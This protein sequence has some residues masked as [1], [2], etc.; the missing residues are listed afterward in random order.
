MLL[1]LFSLLY[2]Y[3][4]TGG[5]T[6]D[7]SLVKSLIY[8]LSSKYTNSAPVVFDLQLVTVLGHL[9]TLNVVLESLINSPVLESLFSN[10]TLVGKFSIKLVTD[11]D[12]TIPPFVSVGKLSLK[13]YSTK[14][15]PFQFQPLGI[16]LGFLILVGN[17]K[18]PLVSD[19]VS[20]I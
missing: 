7:K 10:T 5:V 2:L 16:P 13:L 3:V 8:S 14:G 18:L 17:I 12:G 20:S 11:S 1:L 4:N 19:L 9:Y 15:C 6:T